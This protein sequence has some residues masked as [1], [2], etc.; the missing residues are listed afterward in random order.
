[1]CRCDKITLSPRTDTK[2]KAEEPA[3]AKSEELR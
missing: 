2:A 1:L 3:R